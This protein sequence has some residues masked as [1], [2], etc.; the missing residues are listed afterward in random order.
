MPEAAEY[1]VSTSTSSGS[2]SSDNTSSS[3]STLNEEI[4]TL[5]TDYHIEHGKINS[6]AKRSNKFCQVGFY[7]MNLNKI[8]WKF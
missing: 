2:S 4:Q 3:V 7:F 1:E 6:F 8:V 5:E